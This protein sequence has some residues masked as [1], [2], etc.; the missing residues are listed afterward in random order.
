MHEPTHS[1]S[2]LSLSLSL[3]PSFSPL[4]LCLPPSLSLSPPLSHFSLSYQQH[5]YTNTLVS[6]QISTKYTGHLRAT[7]A[8]KETTQSVECETYLVW[9]VNNFT[10]TKHMYLTQHC[11]KASLHVHTHTVYNITH[12]AICKYKYVCIWR[13]VFTNHIFNLAPLSVCVHVP[14]VEKARAT[15]SG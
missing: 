4:S 7:R 3:S 9:W 14:N 1:S 12:T 5:T 15:E 8:T 6:V 10:N 13:W 2:S 11:L